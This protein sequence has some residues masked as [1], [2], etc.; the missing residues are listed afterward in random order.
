MLITLFLV[1]LE[2]NFLLGLI[3]YFSRAVPKF[4]SNFYCLRV[5]GRLSREASL[6]VT[7]VSRDCFAKLLPI[8]FYSHKT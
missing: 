8:L 6:C 2:D 3:S 5:Y 7:V 4:S 1:I